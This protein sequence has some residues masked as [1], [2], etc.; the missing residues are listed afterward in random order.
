M[1]Q[2]ELAVSASSS[3]N[4]LS[5]HLSSRGETET[6]N[7]Y[8]CCKAILSD[9]STFTL[10]SIAIKKDYS[11]LITLLITQP[12]LHFTSC[13]DRAPRHQR[14]TYRCHLSLPLSNAHRHF[15]IHSDKLVDTISF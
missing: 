3:N 4:A 6:L 2:D 10:H 12:H 5:H 15:G 11:I 1:S 14:S 9:R 7:P 13:L 8:R